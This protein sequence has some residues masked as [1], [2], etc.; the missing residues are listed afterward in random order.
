MALLDAGVPLADIVSGVAMGLVTRDQQHSV[1]TDIMGMEDYMGDMD[2]K[3]A[4][5]KHG[6]CA[7]QADVKIAGISLDIIKE[8]V[9]K[10]ME[11]NHS[12]LDIMGQCIKTPR[13]S[14]ACW[15]VSKQLQI[16]VH[17]RG[18]FLGPGGLNIKKITGE[19][20][21]QIHAEDEGGWTMFA[22]S[23]E[24]MAE[25]DNMLETILSEEKVPELEFGAIYTG[26]I[27][28]M[29]ERG[30]MLELHPGM[31]PM[32][33]T[34]SQLDA[35]KVAHPSALGLQLGQEI[36]VKYYGRD[37]VSGQICQLTKHYYK[38]KLLSGHVRLSRKVLTTASQATMAAASSA[39]RY[40]TA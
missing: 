10:G 28:E 26:K 34:N 23:S 20:G 1:L 38:R 36:Q 4:A 18:K 15:P 3:F 21:V 7:I 19:T 32:M 2:F 30:V 31:E 39:R 17:K 35:R 14:K 5:T 6:V 9:E 8:S 12:I 11:A 24:A 16:P 40:R 37:P 25:A 33:C 29:M 22:P 13:A 27:V